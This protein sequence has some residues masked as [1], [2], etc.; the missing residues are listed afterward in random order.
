MSIKKLL[1]ILLML[2]VVVAGG[3]WYY[4]FQIFI[5]K[6]IAF[7]K[8][9]QELQKSCLADSETRYNEFWDREC[10]GFG[11]RERCRLPGETIERIDKTLSDDKNACSVKYTEAL[12]TINYVF[13][14]DKKDN[15]S[16]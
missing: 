3:A 15:T 9:Q 5:P 4:Y 10:R 2:V 6:K 12:K 16:E 13:P 11:F 8:E 1:I 14:W 7:I